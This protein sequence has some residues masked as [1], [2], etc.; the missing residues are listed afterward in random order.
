MSKLNAIARYELLM[1][2]RRRSLPILWLLLLVGSIFFTTLV[3][4]SSR[5]TAD[6]DQADVVES[7]LA[8]ADLPEWAQ[9]I[10]ML[11]VEHTVGLFSVV[12]T[13]MVFFMVG[14]TL[15]MGEVIPLDRQFK[16]RELLDTL[17]ISRATYL[18][19]KLLGAWIGV[20]LGILIGGALCVV[21]IRL[22]LGIYDLRVFAVMWLVMLTPMALVAA[23][24]SV[25]AGSF[26]GS[27]RTAVLV[28]LLVLPFVMTLAMVA[29]PTLGGIGALIEPIY[30]LVVQMEPSAATNTLIGQ[31]IEDTLLVF[32]GVV[33]AAWTV[34]WGWMRVRS[35]R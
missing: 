15:L 27:R 29:V 28:G 12:I 9:G 16:V 4:N 20:L 26:F 7:T 21:A 5:P 25:L 14:V 11:V 35:A 3:A 32:A 2:W 33:L 10:D 18:V 13:G 34:V 24:L 17:P 23:A 30:A 8:A 6:A 22:I 31:R 19:G 1:A